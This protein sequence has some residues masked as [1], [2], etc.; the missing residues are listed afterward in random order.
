MRAISSFLLILCTGIS[1]LW[2]MSIG[3]SV[4][5]GAIGFQGVYYGTRCLLNQCDP[6]N[7]SELVNFYKGEGHEPPSDSIQR[8]KA[9][10]LYVN[11]PTTFLFIAPLAILPWGPAHTLWT[12]LLIGALIAAS[13]L[14]WRAGAAYADRI[15]LILVCLLLLNCEIVFATG[16]TAGLVVSLSVIAVWSFLTER[17]MPLGVLCLATALAIKPHDAGILWLYFLLA[18]RVH[19]K[20]AL[21]SLAITCAMVLAAVLWVSHATPNWLSEMRSNLAA[22]SLPGGL[23]EPGLNSMTGRTPAMVIS[24]QAVTSAIW[25]DPH[26][27]NLFS[28][29]I[30]GILLFLW[31]LTTLRSRFSQSRAWL[32]LASASALTMLLTYHRPYDAKLLLLT[33]PACTLLWANGGWRRWLAV[34]VTAAGILFTGDIFLALVSHRVRTLDL[35]GATAAQKAF[36]GIIS[37]PAPLVLLVVVVFYLWVYARSSREQTATQLRD[38]DTEGGAMTPDGDLEKDRFDQSRSPQLRDAAQQCPSS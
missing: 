31:V 37:Q 9:V 36:I 27:Y 26:T 38:T 33:I 1:L 6:Y 19:R 21:Q 16:N 10:T 17:F 23:N 34:L 12:L 24:L 4:A 5:G 18:G 32:A 8:R 7:E 35:S 20:R 25:S 28:Y 11:L 3:R 29:L 30:C 13:S 2:G 22:I 15:S 14:M